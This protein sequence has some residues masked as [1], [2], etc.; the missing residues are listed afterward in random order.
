MLTEEGHAKVIDFGIAKLIEAAGESGLDTRT[1]HDTGAGVVL[2]TMTYMSPEQARG[3]R[4]DYRSDIFSFG[5]VLHEMLA[6][7]PPF[8]GKSGIET[9]SAI[10]HE[11]APRLPSL[12]P[13]VVADAGA[14]IQRIVDKCLEKDPDE[15]YQSMKDLAVDLRAARR[16]LETAAQPARFRRQSRHGATTRAVARSLPPAA[17]VVAVAGGGWLVARV[18]SRRAS[19]RQ[20]GCASK[21]S[22]AVLYFDNT[23]GD[24]SL[25][26]MRTGITEMVVTDLSQSTQVEVVEHRA[27]LRHPR[28]TEARRRQGAVARG[29]SRRRRAHRRRQ[30]RGRQLRAI[31]RGPA[32]QHAAAGGG[33]RT[34]RRRRN[35]SRGR[36]RRA[37]LRWST[38][39]RGGSAPV[40]R[41]CAPAS[42][43]LGRCWRRP[44]P[45]SEASLDRGLTDITS[46][47]HRGLP[48]VRRRDEP[49]PAVPRAPGH[50]VLR[51]GRRASIP[52]FASAYAK[53]GD[54]PQQSR[55]NQDLGDKYG[56]TGA[57]ARRPHDAA[58]A[59]LHGRSCCDVRPSA[60][61]RSRPGR[62]P[63][64]HRPLSWLRRLSAQS[65]PRSRRRSDS[66]TRAR[67]TSKKLIRRGGTF[68]ATFT[69]LAGN[70][71][72]LGQGRQGAR[73]GPPLLDAQSGERRR[74]RR[75][76][77]GVARPAVATARRWTPSPAAR[78]STPPPPTSP[79]GHAMAL[80]L[81][82]DW[83][84][85]Q[86]VA[87]SLAAGDDDEQQWFGAIGAVANGA[88]RRSDER[89]AAVDRARHRRLRRAGAAHRPGP[90]AEGDR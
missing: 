24:A 23:T 87:A 25:D 7:R 73:D 14:D 82:D 8:Q 13:G 78:C 37:C 6:G 84:G 3:D 32:H 86:K 43:R 10:L 22:V 71:L 30:R 28:R 85:A 36:T 56:E 46:A 21:P 75:R 74:A 69:F 5:I 63:A 51:E 16:R 72:A 15:R 77:Q 89:G 2:G 54:D 68:P 58:R 57:A 20:R 61:A 50:P 41:R 52:G 83:T 40:S 29:D 33:D 1:S 26:W 65:R 59:P 17:A 31:G 18:G 90:D 47:V 88:V 39:C 60:D 62:L 38:T 80:M 49:A 70:Y 11:P 35:G 19:P 12:G 45:T 81:Q 9:A 67:A 34:H 27:P 55:P 42:A 4:V 53:L 48:G 79:F 64:L 76:R 44:A 66:S